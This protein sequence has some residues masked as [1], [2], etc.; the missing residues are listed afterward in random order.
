V[1]GKRE[2]FVPQLSCPIQADLNR[3]LAYSGNSPTQ[4]KTP[5]VGHR[6]LSARG[7][8]LDG[9]VVAQASTGSFD[10]GLRFASES[11]SCAQ[12]DKVGSGKDYSGSNDTG[13][14]GGGNS[15]TDAADRARRTGRAD[16]GAERGQDSCRL[17][18]PEMHKRHFG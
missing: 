3:Q 5:C 16:A 13:E 1:K 14:F 4:R 15:G 7:E 10:S 17:K 2:G 11:Q 6:P 12:D 18:D 8:L 9:A